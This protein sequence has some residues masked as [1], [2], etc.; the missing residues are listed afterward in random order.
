M[1]IL[2]SEIRREDADVAR[3]ESLKMRDRGEL[4]DFG[5]KI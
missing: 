5:V 4:L 1:R 2:R 3:D